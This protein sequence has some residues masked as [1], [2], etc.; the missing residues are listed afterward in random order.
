MTHLQSLKTVRAFA[1]LFGCFYI[2]CVD[3]CQDGQ[4]FPE[5]LTAHTKLL[6]FYS[7]LS[8]EFKMCETSI[9]RS[10]NSYNRHSLV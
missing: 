8:Q 5:E 10:H 3:H 7:I 4:N 6:F 1:F 2:V 9:Q